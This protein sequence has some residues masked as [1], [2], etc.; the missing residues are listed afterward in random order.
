METH[1]SVL[2][3]EKSMENYSPWGHNESDVAEHAHAHTC[4]EGDDLIESCML[5]IRVRRVG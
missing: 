5:R 1:S 3:L 2:C 4:T